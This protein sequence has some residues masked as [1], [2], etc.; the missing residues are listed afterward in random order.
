MQENFVNTNEEEESESE[1]GVDEQARQVSDCGIVS[2]RNA[3]IID[4][5]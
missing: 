2:I 3:E 5:E 1:A 4:N